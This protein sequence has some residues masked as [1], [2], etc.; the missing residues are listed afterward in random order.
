MRPALAALAL[1]PVRV[2]SSAACPEAR[3][4]A[5]ARYGDATALF[6]DDRAFPEPDGFWVAGGRQAQ[7][8][9]APA[10]SGRTI[11]LFVRNGAVANRVRLSDGTWSDALEM[12]P[13]EER[14]VSVPLDSRSGAASLLIRSE[15]GFRPAE[16]DAASDDRRFL[17]LLG[18]R[19]ALTPRR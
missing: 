19:P 18:Q 5:G 15:T 14:L 17:G 8:V 4:R 10:S 12:G 16:V 1:Q 7:V 13:G 11:T 6:F 2:T 3:A 9:V